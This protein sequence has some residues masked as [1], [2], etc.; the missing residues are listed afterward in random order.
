M[1]EIGHR[2]AE[3][4]QPA[5]EIFEQRIRWSLERSQGRPRHPGEEPDEM[6]RWPRATSPS[7]VVDNNSRTKPEGSD[8]FH[9]RVLRIEHLERFGRVGDLEDESVACRGDQQEVLIALT[10][11]GRGGAVE[12][13]QLVRQS[14][15]AGDIE[16][17]RL[18]QHGHRGILMCRD[19]RH[20]GT[21]NPLNSPGPVN[22]RAQSG[23]Q[24][25]RRSGDRQTAR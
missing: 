11:Q 6:P 24:E 8:V 16:T 2:G 19:A 17:R 5:A 23:P 13:V 20:G 1:I 7:I 9:R 12:S 10:R 22:E 4:S 14:R 21:Y 3:V 18:L 25:I 15:C